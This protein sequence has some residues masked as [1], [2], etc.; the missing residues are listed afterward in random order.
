MDAPIPQSMPDVLQRI[1]QL[2]Y[3]SRLRL[4]QKFFDKIDRLVDLMAKIDERLDGHDD[5]REDPTYREL[6]GYRIVNHF[7]VVTSSLRAELSN[8]SDFS[9]GSI[10]ARID[11][12]Y[13]DALAQGIGRVDSPALR[14]GATKEW[15]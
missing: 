6:C 9:R 12:G 4:D 14:S 8:A 10:E 3:T 11:A 2:Q 1:V 15:V 13:R 5:I 7:I